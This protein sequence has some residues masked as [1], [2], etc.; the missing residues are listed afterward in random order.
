[1]DLDEERKEDPPMRPPERPPPRPAMAGA[2]STATPP[3]A[4]RRRC[5]CHL[6]DGVPRFRQV[7]KLFLAGDRAGRILDSACAVRSC[8]DL[9]SSARLP[10][11]PR[12]RR[13]RRRV[14]ESGAFFH[15]AR[16]GR[17]QATRTLDKLMRR[18][19]RRRGGPT[20]GRVHPGGSEIDG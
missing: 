10:P 16:A 13:A 9:R 1:M 4:P 8:E 12:P 20:A 5:L 17:G 3:R 7:E 18:G 11:P 19:R 2:A 6:P 14:T 15:R